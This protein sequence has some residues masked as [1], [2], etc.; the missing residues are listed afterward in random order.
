MRKLVY[1]IAFILLA[2]AFAPLNAQPAEPPLIGPLLAVT[3]AEQDRIILYDIGTGGKRTLSFSAGWH[4]VWGFSAD[5]CRVIFSLSDGAALAKL[6]SARLDGT[7]KRDLVTFTDAPAGTWG[8]WDA[9]PSPTEDR[10]AFT[11]KVARTQ[12]DGTPG[13]EQRIAWVSGAGGTPTFYRVTG[14][15]AEPEWSANGRWLV[16]TSYTLRVPGANLNATAAPRQ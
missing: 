12:P 11:L 1:F 14:D 6:Y 3:T 13:F 9:Q 16:Y 2:T 10:I 7:D 4:N 8:V 15:E 5:G